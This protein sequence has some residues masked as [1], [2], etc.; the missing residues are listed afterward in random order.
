M[1]WFAPFEQALERLGVESA[2]GHDASPDLPQLPDSWVSTNCS[3]LRVASGQA[4]SFR[5]AN[6]KEET[7]YEVGIFQTGSVPCRL[8][9]LGFDEQQERHDFLNALIWLS[10]PKTKA[11]LNQFQA[12]AIRDA[13]SL[14]T[15]GPLRDSITTFDENA[16]ILLT[17]SDQP[18]Q[19][20]KNKNWHELFVSQ[21]AAWLS[22]QWLP[23]CFGHALLQK[24]DRPYKAITA[25]TLVLPVSANELMT[26]GANLLAL[27][28]AKLSERLTVNELQQKPYLPLP[29]LGIPGWCEA[30]QD[31]H[32]Y[33]DKQVFR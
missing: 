1:A 22:K 11:L 8:R 5:P 6:T 18:V 31:P 30:N 14:K 16:M 19:W 7:H 27:V 20:L 28:D 25:H 12:Q 10:F 9:T 15:R 32:F 2:Q 21:R 29:V 17:A 26:E 24:L 4:L 33:N 23:I 3:G 13:G